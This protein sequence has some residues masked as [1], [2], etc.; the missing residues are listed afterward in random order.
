MAPDVL[1][2]A[3]GARVMLLKNL[4]ASSK[5]VNGARGTV[6][7]FAPAH[8]APDVASAPAVADA[9]AVGA[10]GPSGGEAEAREDGEPT[11]LYPVVRFDGTGVERLLTPEEWTV[12]QGGRVVARHVQVPCLVVLLVL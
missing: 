8:A 10:D 2:L 12:E 3:M 4:D 6:C 1:E 5:L 9:G 7:G 11:G